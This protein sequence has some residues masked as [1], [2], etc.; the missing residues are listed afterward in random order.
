MV[1]RFLLSKRMQPRM[2]TDDKKK[3]DS[4]WYVHCFMYENKATHRRGM[5]Y[6]AK[7]DTGETSVQY[8]DYTT[9]GMGGTVH[10][11][12]WHGYWVSTGLDTLDGREVKSGIPCACTSTT[13]AGKRMPKG[14]R[15][16]LALSVRRICSLV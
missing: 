12:G 4:S 6:I 9:G 1:L 8:W 10:K 5:L 16:P 7:N 15:Y 14:S 11:S 2:D 3:L 13:P